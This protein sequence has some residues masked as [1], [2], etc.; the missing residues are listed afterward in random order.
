[1]FYE[2]SADICIRS[3]EKSYKK[4]KKNS[5]NEIAGRNC[6]I[7]Q[8]ENKNK[9]PSEIWKFIVCYTENKQYRNHVC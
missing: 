1:M 6:Y 8:L 4:Y 9:I 2:V 7:I 3:G 5:K